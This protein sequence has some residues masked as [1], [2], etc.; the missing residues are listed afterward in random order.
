MRD[1]SFRDLFFLLL[2]L[3]SILLSL[4]SSVREKEESEKGGKGKTYIE[5]IYE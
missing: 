2:F 3:S 1:V 5:I 4:L